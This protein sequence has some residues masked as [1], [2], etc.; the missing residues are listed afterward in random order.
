[1]STRLTE[2][3]RPSNWSEVVG[4]TDIVNSIKA[5]I[6]NKDKLGM[7]HY[8]FVGPTPGTGKTTIAVLIAKS[9][10][11]SFHEFNA[12]DERGID[13][14]REEIKRLAQYRGERVVFLDEADQLTSPAQNALRRIVE[15]TEGTVFIFTGNYEDQIIDAMKS[16]CVIH[17]FPPLTDQDVES[18]IVEI[19]KGEK[20]KLDADTPEKQQRVRAGIARLVETSN[21]DL[22]TAINNLM[23][24]ID[25]GLNI[26]P[27]SVAILED[28]T[29]LHALA[30]KYALEGNFVAAK[31][32]I[33]KAHVEGKYNSRMTFKELY[34][35]L[36]TVEDKEVRIRLFSKLGE[37]EQNSKRGSDPIIQIVAFM[38]YVWLVPHLSKCPVLQK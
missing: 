24:I 36:D 5:N 15:Q 33:E 4:Q 23:K 35:A 21:G 14:I 22:R 26:S 8:L 12:S 11:V 25:D 2:K 13:F 19:I 29:P 9:L 6:K 34:K 10:G 17:R 37:V 38:A 1:M 31:D 3:Y 28:A 7:P 18:K 20:V 30:L 32:T 27:E 16:R